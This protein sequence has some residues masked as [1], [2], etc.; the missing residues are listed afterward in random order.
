MITSLIL[1][2]LS[3]FREGTGRCDGSYLDVNVLFLVS[4]LL[5]RSRLSIHLHRFELAS[6]TLALIWHFELRLHRSI[7]R[8]HK[9][10]SDITLATEALFLD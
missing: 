5:P 2:F 10:N 7:F 6:L 1:V 3:C 8:I 4:L 9:Q